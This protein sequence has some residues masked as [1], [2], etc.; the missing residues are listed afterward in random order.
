M[1]SDESAAIPQRPDG[2]GWVPWMDIEAV[3]E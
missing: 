2:R 1:A 3:R